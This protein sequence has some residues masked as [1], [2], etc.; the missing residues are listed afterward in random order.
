MTKL[1]VHANK[2]LDKGPFVTR[3]AIYD[4]TE[5]W[6]ILVSQNYTCSLAIVWFI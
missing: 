1:H 6:L 5:S 2:K 4:V 3:D